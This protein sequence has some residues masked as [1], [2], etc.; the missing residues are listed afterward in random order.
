MLENMHLY[1]NL[2]LRW[3]DFYVLSMNLH[4]TAQTWI[5]INGSSEHCSIPNHFAINVLTVLRLISNNV[6]LFLTKLISDIVYV[7][8]SL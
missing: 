2:T 1:S 4:D 6:M 5:K 3:C 8:K 7:D